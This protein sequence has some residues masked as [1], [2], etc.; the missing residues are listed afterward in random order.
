MDTVSSNID[1]EVDML[2][3][4][5]KT[6]LINGLRGRISVQFNDSKF[7]IKIINLTQVCNICNSISSFFIPSQKKYFFTEIHLQF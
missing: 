2:D 1:L 7:Y 6:A 4:L 5:L 3:D